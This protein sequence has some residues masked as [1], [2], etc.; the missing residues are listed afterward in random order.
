MKTTG[1]RW[2]LIALLFP[3]L[4]HAQV[5]YRGVVTDADTNE[6][7]E[8]ATVK[9]V[10]G[11]GEV[12][13][14][15]TFTDAGGRFSVKTERQRDSL[16]LTVSMLGY[17]TGRQPAVAGRQAGFSLRPAAIGLREVLIKPGRIR[18]RNDTINYSIADFLSSKDE[19]M[20]DVLK[21]LPGL[22]VDNS[23]KI[24]YNGKNISNFYVEGMD[25]AGGR[26]NQINNNL[27]ARAV[28]AVQVLE[29]H[30]PVRMLKDKM[31]TDDVAI[32][33]KLKPE[34]R[35]RWMAN[36]HTA[37]GYSQENPYGKTLW[38]ADVNA[39]QISRK[40]QS[41]YIYK[42]NNTGHDI[43]DENKVLT[44]RATGGIRDV[45][46]PAFLGQP[47]LQAPLKTERHLFNNVHTASVN[48]L[49]KVGETAQLRLNMGYTHDVRRQERGS[50]TTYYQPGD[51]IGISEQSDT[52]IRSDAAEL[53]LNLENNAG[54]Y[55]LTNRFSAAGSREKGTSHYTGG[56]D[57]T[58]EIKTSAP[59]A[60]NEL[61]TLWKKESH[62]LELNSLVRFDHSPAT[63]SAEGVVDRQYLNLNRLY[64]DNRFSIL[65]KKGDYTR[66]YSAGVK[67]EITNIRNSYTPY[68][69]PQWQI[70]KNDVRGT[71][72][73]PA[74]WHKLPGNDFARPAVHPSASVR[75]KLN[76]AWQFTLY[77]GYTET[78]GSMV[79]LYDT[80]YRKNYLHT[81]INSGKVTVN[82]QQ[83]YSLYG[84]YKNTVKEFFTTL[85]IAHTRNWSN[86][87]R[88]EIIGNGEVTAASREQSTKANGWTANGTISK[89]I[90]DRGLKMSLNYIFGYRKAG[91]I[92]LG[93]R[94][95]IKSTYMLYEPKIV[96]NPVAGMEIGYQSSLRYGGTK[97]GNDTKLQPLWNIVQKMNLSYDFTFVELAV[98]A[99]HY[100]NDVSREQGK[101]T[102]L[103][104]ASLQ[105]K[106][107]R[108]QITLTA[109]N[110]LNKN[111]YRYTQYT[112]IQSYT[113]WVNI[114]GRELLAAVRYRW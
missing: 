15:Y 110:L 10:S 98:T 51:T 90:H 102:C 9:L 74:T 1:R 35:D 12:L 8:M 22:D 3:A 20:K 55:Y 30:Q 17:E 32:N 37:A 71:L 23:G 64:T 88:E 103:V 114:R 53:G 78:Y 40:S 69:I 112:E 99:D 52:R 85:T 96:W 109:N 6:P 44:A 57:F 101:N 56:K 48:R 95:Q 33:L 2:L 111:Q 38:E 46:L 59:G 89:G 68:V 75:Y 13:I 24:S 83:T 34:F 67:G 61:R 5:V 105:R 65:K 77:G 79:D 108:W 87:I 81:Q 21:K 41:S 84:E 93:E 63:L 80:P 26:Y 36:L 25:L 18:S 49:Y 54:E 47:S 39:L 97:I 94:V 72:T 76:Y 60:K 104:D 107:G 19:S 91:Q 58:Q 66:R 14:G 82:R 45:P 43:T 11:N 31:Y 92:S 27:Q 70:N 29:N 7:L 62:T 113:S 106:S 42:T 28:D 100:Y 16:R 86:H 4:L 73:I 50:L